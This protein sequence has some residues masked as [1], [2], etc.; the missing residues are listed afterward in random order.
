MSCKN[1]VSFH[2]PRGY[3]YSEIFVRCGNTDPR[4]GRAICKECRKDPSEMRAIRN[5]EETIKADNAA[6]KSAGYGEI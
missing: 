4:G 5:H 1:K 2:V 3:D 6:L